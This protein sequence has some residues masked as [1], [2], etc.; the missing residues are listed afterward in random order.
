[1]KFICF[2]ILLI[3]MTA[4]C[5][6][7]CNPSQIG[8]FD[9]PCWLNVESCADTIVCDEG[10]DQVVASSQSEGFNLFSDEVRCLHC[11][12]THESIF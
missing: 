12:N 9:N 1:M 11:G 2:S 10:E 7:E 5:S 4:L 3:S 8:N 6:G